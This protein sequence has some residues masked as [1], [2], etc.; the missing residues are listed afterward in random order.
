[1][2]VR[3]LAILRHK[4]HGLGHDELELG[5]EDGWLPERAAAIA[6]ASTRPDA[7]LVAV[8]LQC[9]KSAVGADLRKSSMAWLWAVRTA[10]AARPQRA[11]SIRPPRMTRQDAIWRSMGAG[12]WLRVRT[13]RATH[14][15]L[16]Q[17]GADGALFALQSDGN[18][19]VHPVALSAGGQWRRLVPEAIPSPSEFQARLPRP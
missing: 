2:R 6:S 9:E 10:E 7:R 16:S 3:F 11:W 17:I 12:A 8:A 13:A 15:R 5:K 19:P 14:R 4:A 18:Q 1:L